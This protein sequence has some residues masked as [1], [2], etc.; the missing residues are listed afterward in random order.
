[1]TSPPA[2]LNSN[3][4]R[5]W[6]WVAMLTILGAFLRI[7]GIN[8]GLW[9]D[10]IYFVVVTVRHPLAEIVTVFPG[11]NQHPLYSILSWI[12]VHLFGEHPWTLRL[13]ALLFGVASIPMLYRLGESV[14]S[15]SQALL[16]AAI[17]TVSYHHVWFSQN[18][19]GYSTLAFWTILSTDLLLRGIRTGSQKSYYAYAVAAALGAFTH[20]TMMFVIASHVLICAGIFFSDRKRNPGSKTWKPPLLGFLLTG[21]LILLF[22]SPILTQ[23]QNFFMHRPSRMKAVSTPTWAFWETL[24]GLSVGFGTGGILACVGLVVVCGA[25]SYYKQ[26]RVVFSLFALPAVLTA[27]G[28]FLSRGTMY[29]RFYFYLIGFA[30]MILVRGLF[31][32]PAWIAAHWP[33]GSADTATRLGPALTAVFA[34]V[35]LG[36]S[37]YSLVRNYEFPK[38][39][40]EGAMHFVDGEI[41]SGDAVVTA[42]AAIYPYQQYYPTN[43]EAV[44]TPEKLLEICDS[45]RPVWMIYTFPRYLEAAYPAISDMIRKDFTTVRVFPGTVGDGEVFVSRF[46]PKVK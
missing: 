35:V 43:F 11:D 22:Y 27:L 17:L 45:G 31:V 10:E 12:S 16:A 5:F 44:E 15:R 25:W 23:V 19:R 4:Q 9:W 46:Q 42:G 7:A 13:P 38:Q 18:A 34:A 1:M 26:D 40:F 21:G 36:V 3:S 28:A 32:I 2:E 8:K 24:R 39:D 20:L 14:T 29:P 37:T 33:G 41:K 6:L 30:L